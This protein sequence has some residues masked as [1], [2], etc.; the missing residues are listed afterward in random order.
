AALKASDG[1]ASA[2]RTARADIARHNRPRYERDDDEG[3]GVGGILGW[4]FGEGDGGGSSSGWSSSSR[5][6]WSSSS[7]SRSSGRSSSRSRS[8]SSSRRSGGS[9]SSSS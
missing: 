2:Q 9:R 6:S 4:L 5:S 7:R 3:A 1:A 8:S